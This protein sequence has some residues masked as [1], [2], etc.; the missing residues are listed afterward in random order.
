[1]KEICGELADLIEKS[2]CGDYQTLSLDYCLQQLPLVYT[3][4]L[5]GDVHVALEVMNF[6]RAILSLLHK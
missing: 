6:G 2:P 3:P 4:A 1:M 5:G